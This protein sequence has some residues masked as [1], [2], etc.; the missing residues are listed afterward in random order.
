MKFFS[1]FA[2]VAALVLGA[3]GLPARAEKADRD[4]PMQLEAD[5]MQHDEGK[6]VT[7]LTGQVQA[8][9]GTL[10]MRAARME[11][12]Q[13]AQGQQLARFWAEPGQ[14]VF[15]RQKREGLDEYVEGEAVE[16]DYDSRQDRMV[17][18]GNAEVRLLRE[19]R[20]ADQI[21]GQRIVYNNSTE[22]LQV[23]GQPV[24]GGPAGARPRV[25]AVL[26]P[27]AAPPAAGA[28]APALRSSPGLESGAR[29]P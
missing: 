17:L 18:T 9:K 3:G 15:F 2:T 5:R 19:G 27:K 23:D 7:V 6:Q 20:L 24:P 10:V 28:S 4:K 14:R 13:D 21:L 29:T 11:V 12:Q 1:V 22:V 25:R 16:A 8:V 26:S